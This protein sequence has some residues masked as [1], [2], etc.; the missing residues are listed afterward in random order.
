MNNIERRVIKLVRDVVN[1]YASTT[2]PTFDEIC[3]GLRL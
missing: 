1:E 2:I 3:S